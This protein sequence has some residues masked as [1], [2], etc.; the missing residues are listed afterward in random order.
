MRITNIAF[1]SVALAG[2]GAVDPTSENKTSSDD[3]EQTE[4]Q[5]ALFT[6]GV[7]VFLRNPRTWQSTYALDA[8]GT[9][10]VV[11]NPIN[12][13]NYQRWNI[14]DPV[15]L[16]GYA[17]ETGS[18]LIQN[19][20]HG[21]CLDSNWAGD[22]YTLPCSGSANNYQQW[23]DLGPNSTW[24]GSRNIRNVATH[25]CINMTT[26]GWTHTGNCNQSAGPQRFTIY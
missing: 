4:T 12:G 22:I 21:Q 5:S 17:A 2:C 25:Y 7:T 13:G 3:I 24:P 19:F 23:T 16:Y 9:G 18:V 14:V 26:N 1:L 15:P 20:Q 6:T 11:G 8:N 10:N